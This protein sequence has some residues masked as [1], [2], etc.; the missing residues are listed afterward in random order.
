MPPVCPFSF[1]YFKG[2]VVL[3]PRPALDHDPPDLCLQVTGIPSMY[4]Q[5][6]SNDFLMNRIWHWALSL[7]HRHSGLCL[8]PSWIT[9]SWGN[10]SYWGHSSSS[11]ER[12]PA[13]NQGNELY[14]KQIL[15]PSQAFNDCVL[16]C[17][18]DCNPEVL[19]KNHQLNCSW[20]AE[21]CE[22]WKVHWAKMQNV[23]VISHVAI[24]NTHGNKATKSSHLHTHFQLFLFSV[25]QGIKALKSVTTVQVW[26]PDE[27]GK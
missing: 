3:L 5:A 1:S 7:E 19:R 13:N 25:Y 14:R 4:H 2:R 12:H 21:I 9:Y 27:W 17:Y 15:Q 23:L 6:W 18:L 22:M 11:I 26:E 16:C 10:Q 24:T 8:P 20:A